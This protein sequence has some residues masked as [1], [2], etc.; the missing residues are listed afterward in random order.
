MMSQSVLAQLSVTEFFQGYNWSGQPPK[1]ESLLQTTAIDPASWLTLSVGDFLSQSNWHGSPRGVQPKPPQLEKALSLT[2]TVQEY[3]QYPVWQGQ[4]HIAVVPKDP[5]RREAKTKA[6][7]KYQV[8][9]L[10]HLF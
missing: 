2:L 1:L 7:E 8:T 6:T 9:D 5:V 10:T 3:F 4:P